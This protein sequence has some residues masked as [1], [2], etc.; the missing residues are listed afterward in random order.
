[1]VVVVIVIE[2]QILGLKNLEIGLVAGCHAANRKPGHLSL[3]R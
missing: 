2:S 1:M 3:R